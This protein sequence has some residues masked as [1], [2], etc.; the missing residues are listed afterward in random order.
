MQISLYGSHKRCCYW[1]SV[2]GV[3]CKSLWC[4]N[5]GT[6]AVRAAWLHG[7]SGRTPGSPP[8]R[9]R[10]SWCDPFTPV[11]P[12]RRLLTGRDPAQRITPRNSTSS[13]L[14]E[15]ND[16][17]RHILDPIMIY[18]SCQIAWIGSCWMWSSGEIIGGF[19]SISERPVLRHTQTRWP[20]TWLNSS[21]SHIRRCSSFPETRFSD[22]IW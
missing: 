9:Y 19:R 5:P 15:I 8:R 14:P 21:K 10:A 22:S 6:I 2:G 1:G 4:I 20:T 3:M 12:P 7:R 16:G 17:T 18:T 13:L 11:C